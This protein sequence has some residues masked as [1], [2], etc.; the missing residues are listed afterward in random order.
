MATPNIIADFKTTLA[1]K[2]AV[3]DT[4]A[5]L[6]IAT[7]SDG[8][9][10][11]A[12]TYG[13]T[14]D[15]K[16]SSKEYIVCTLSGVNLTAV[17]TIARGTGA[18][19]SGFAKVHRKGAEIIISDFVSIKRLQDVLEIGYPSAV[20]PTS[21]YQ[22]ATKKYVDDLAL[23]GTTT[24]DRLVIT[25][26][27]GENVVAG[28]LLYLKVSDSKWYKT[29]G[30]DLTTINNAGLGIAQG[31]GS[32]G[33]VITGGVLIRGV[34][35]NQTGMTANS[36]YYISDTPGAISATTGTVN[37]IIGLATANNRLY[38]D[39]EFNKKANT[40]V[41]GDV[42]IATD[43]EAIAGTNQNSAGNNLVVTPGQI[44][45][46]GNFG[47]GSDG[48]VTI[49]AGTTTL[50]R[51]MYY[52]NLVVTGT[53]FTAGWRI[54]VKETI[55]GAGIIDFS[56]NPGGNGGNGQYNVT[57]GAAGAAPTTY[58]GYFSNI[59]GAAGYSAGSSLGSGGHV[60]NNGA[61]QTS[62]ID[63]ASAGSNGGHGTYDQY[64]T[65]YYGG[66]GGSVSR[67]QRYVSDSFNIIKVLDLNSSGALIKYVPAGAAGSGG[68]GGN[69]GAG[70]RAC[71]GS[72]AG[73]ASGG[74]VYICAKYWTGTFTIQA[75][76]GNGG[77]GG[78]GD[79]G[80]AAGGGGGGNGGISIVIYGT[81]S[82]TGSY[83]L[84]GGTGGIAG[85][86]YNGGYEVA[87]NGG[88]GVSGYSYEFSKLKVL[89]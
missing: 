72:G 21:P 33:G 28:N 17:S 27:C 2:V 22:L 36:F 74:I 58:T 70:G 79:S 23:G 73:G 43:A 6:S 84:T 20:T 69:F 82:W 44:P 65:N 68:F 81:K 57:H 50:T 64:G 37:R 76:G 52:N 56:G 62:A 4:T 1:L 32:T 10:L 7:D 63:N 66:T 49:G 38:F 61:N 16:N 88:N 40:S 75:K 19:T 14:I 89:I 31:T 83:V 12:G 42:E 60:G 54:F 85:T 86:G 26:V 78:N 53:I 80:G 35:A 24:V 77:N 51:D 45:I 46:L 8:V 59:A 47:D 29:N 30:T 15:R 41:M 48:D 13:F 5:T 9:A 39:A 67:F 3:G 11:P 87:Q 18:A 25:G 71:G 34:D 55:S